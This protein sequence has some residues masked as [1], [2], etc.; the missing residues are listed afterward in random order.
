MIETV[1]NDIL[2]K[3]KDISKYYVNNLDIKNSSISLFGGLGGISLFYFEKIHS[4]ISEE[5][6]VMFF[7]NL[8]DSIT[9][10]LNEDDYS[11]TFCD[12]LAGIAF[13]FKKYR[14]YLFENGYEIDE[15]LNEIEEILERTL[16]T[17][18]HNDSIKFEYLDFLHGNL[19]ILYYFIYFKSQ[20][21]NIHKVYL[22]IVTCIQEHLLAIL[23]GNG[24]N[25]NFGLAHGLCSMI[26]VC[27]QYNKNY[28]DNEETQKLLKI[29]EKI[30]I[31]APINFNNYSLFP[32]IS[33]RES[34]AEEAKKKFPLGWCYG[35]QTIS[36]SLYKLSLN[37]RSESLK[38]LSYKVSNH[39]AKKNTIGKALCND[40]F[41]DFS[42]C[43]GI[44]SVILLNNK[45]YD[46]TKNDAFLQ[47][48]IYFLKETLKQNEMPDNVAGYKKCERTGTYDKDWGMLLGSIGVGLTLISC[49]K[50][51]NTMLDIL[52]I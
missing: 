3:I 25:I 28:G 4:D 48:T 51:D 26:N 22:S 5:E 14:N 41:Y 44:S 43:H 19:G 20:R 31:E 49:I 35:D 23:N 46:I 39:W 11:L 37:N 10:K 8:I 27:I 52:L 33:T 7:F 40:S 15:M 38:K 17:Y 13:I 1:R 50:R 47:N 24:K 12:G 45:W 29:I 16:I 36:L 21:S 30:Y 34:F 9:D 32:A 18:S 42:V 2:N 6:D